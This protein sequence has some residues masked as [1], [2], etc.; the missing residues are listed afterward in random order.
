MFVAVA[1]DFSSDDHAEQ[2]VKLLG[3]YGFEKVQEGLWE[4][5]SIPENTLSRLKRDIDK[6]CDS[7]DSIRFYQFP[8]EET[9]IITSLKGKR[10]RRM[11]LE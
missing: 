4:S 1:C 5:Q 2:V 11:I 7:Y 6:A 9:M 10:W 8:L 3:W